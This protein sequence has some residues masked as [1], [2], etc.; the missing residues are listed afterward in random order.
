MPDL[1][2]AFADDELAALYDLFSPPGERDDFQFYLPLIMAAG[3]VLD[4]AC[5][6]GALLHLAREAGHPGRLVGLDP[7]PGMLKQARQRADIEWVL[8]DLTTARWDR[9]FEL[10]V[11]TG[12]AFQELREDAEIRTALATIRSALTAGGRFAFE[13]RN[14]LVRAWEQ[15]PARYSGTVTTPE[16]ATVR[17]DYYVET[18]VVGDL[19]RYGSTFTS[20]GWDRPRPSHGALRFLSADRFATLLAEAGLAIEE[21]YGTWQHGPLSDTAPEIITVARRR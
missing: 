5:G 10:I 13:T 2:A 18:P 16:G 15:W 7:A 20:P 11:M 9:E 19:V 1:Q 21:Q 14:P 12:H 17:C 4:V 8:G 6:T 3:S